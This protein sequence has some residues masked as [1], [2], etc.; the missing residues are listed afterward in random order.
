MSKRTDRARGSSS[1]DDAITDAMAH[2]KITLVALEDNP[3]I[4]RMAEHGKKFKD[5]REAAFDATKP[6]RLAMDSI[7]EE[8]HSIEP[9]TQKVANSRRNKLEQFRAL[10]AAIVDE[11]QHV[12]EKAGFTIE[13]KDSSTGDGDTNRGKLVG[14][15]PDSGPVGQEDARN[16]PKMPPRAK[17]A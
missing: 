6:Y 9:T 5:A 14:H 7:I 15:P 2:R 13:D 4:Q 10:Q 12:F 16:S 17:E 8:L 3:E 11:R 1:N